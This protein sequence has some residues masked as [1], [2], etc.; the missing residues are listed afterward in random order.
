[1][2]EANT[3]L[4][5]ASLVTPPVK[6]HVA[7]VRYKLTHGAVVAAVIGLVILVA[8]AIHQNLAS[9]GIDF[10]FAYLSAPSRFGISEGL[11]PVWTGWAPI[12][13]SVDASSSNLAMLEAGLFNTLK[14]A[15]LAI[16]FS[17]LVGV[18][19]G[20]LR[21]STNWL[22]RNLAFAIGEFIRNTPILIQLMFWYFAVLLQLP[23]YGSATKVSKWFVV[24]QSGVFLPLPHLSDSAGPASALFV[25][26]AIAFLSAA[27]LRRFPA[28]W[29]IALLGVGLCVIGASYASGFGINLDWPV[30]GRF[31]AT[32]G[33]HFTPEMS[34]ILI[35]IIVN[36]AGYI[37]EIVRG[38]IE[39]LPKG[40]WEAA[41]ALGLSRRDTMRDIVLPQV[42]RIIIP[43]L[44]NRY[45]SLTKDTSIGI[46]IGFPDLFSVS[47][48]VASQTGRDFEIFIVVMGVYLLLSW[49]ISGLTNF[50]N[51]WIALET[52]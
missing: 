35:T 31:G 34:A 47:G 28:R 6:Q 13:E 27:C 51:R 10:S 32:G 4:E 48:T 9:R 39:G 21:L 24:G 14:V 38:A 33:L 7:R 17:T 30:L 50:V 36:S 41:A 37:S 19:L 22:L 44:T 40:Q 15:L 20:V 29:R 25:A 26:V 8:L 43:S 3:K 12:F 52:A 23:S 46:A 1:M 49:L 18:G 16:T 42:F 45:I 2:I 5:R 11:A